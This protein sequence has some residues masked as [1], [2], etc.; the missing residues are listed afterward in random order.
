MRSAPRACPLPYS[1]G[2]TMRAVA[3]NDASRRAGA[4]L[5]PHFGYCSAPGSAVRLGRTRSLLQLRKVISGYLL[6]CGAAFSQDTT[7]IVEGRVLDAS[8]A[9]IGG[10]TIRATN[11]A[12]GSTRS[13]TASNAG[14]YHLA[15]PAAVYDLDV[16]A[17]NFGR[18]TRKDV[19]LSVS[20]T[21]RIDF[22]L[23]VVRDKD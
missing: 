6:L 5:I 16:Q 20:Q 8:G 4:E 3:P 1:V 7:A 9:V 22:S 15:L 21:T 10:A 11:P 18:V 12:T 17:S 2:R 19:Q 13:Q 23:A 14:T